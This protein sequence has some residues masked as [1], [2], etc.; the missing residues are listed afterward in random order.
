[1]QISL[2]IPPC[3]NCV[4]R[5]GSSQDVSHS[6]LHGVFFSKFCSSCRLPNLGNCAVAC[7]SYRQNQC[8]HFLWPIQSWRI[9][10]CTAVL[11]S[12]IFLRELDLASYSEKGGKL[13]LS[14]PRSGDLLVCVNL[15]TEPKVNLDASKIPGLQ[16]ARKSTFK[17][18][19]QNKLQTSG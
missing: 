4:A 15:G 14:R 2:A 12:Q 1:M 9:I 19:T 5:L 3:C 10:L 17:T 11:I 18:V 7:A 8:L 16:H 13:E 6:K